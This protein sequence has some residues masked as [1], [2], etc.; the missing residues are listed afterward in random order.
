MESICGPPT[1]STSS[2]TGLAA[3]RR[4]PVIGTRVGR[5]VALDAGE[6]RDPDG[7]PLRYR[8]FHYQEAGSAGANL[9]AV[10]IAG[11]DTAKAV[12]TP[13]AVCR[14]RWLPAPGRCSG[15]GTAH[16]I[17]GGDR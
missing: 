13:T 7:Q 15:T 9:A 14:P 17:R 11:A 10:T 1:K 5:P 16:I 6:S 2:N 4:S 8:W 3:L 12:V